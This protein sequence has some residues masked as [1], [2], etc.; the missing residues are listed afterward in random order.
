MLTY[1]GIFE[2][3]D[4]LITNQDVI[5]AKPNPACYLMAMKKLGVKPSETIIIE[6]SPYGIEAGVASGATVIRV[7]SV[8][9]VTLD[10]LRD[11]LPEMFS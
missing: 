5:E 11:Y 1:A 9:D 8:H 6:D 3:L 4:I 2:L 10:L 7:K